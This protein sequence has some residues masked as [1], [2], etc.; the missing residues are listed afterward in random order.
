MFTALLTTSRIRS[1]AVSAGDCT[2]STIGWTD[3]PSMTLPCRCGRWSI[4]P[5]GWHTSSTTT[6]PALAG[7]N[8]MP[9]RSRMGSVMSL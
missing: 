2:S 3:C 4:S 9:K 6:E 1:T 8:S 7:I 5:D